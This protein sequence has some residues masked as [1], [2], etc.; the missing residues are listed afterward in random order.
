MCRRGARAHSAGTRGRC[1]MPPLCGLSAA[2]L[3]AV[4]RPSSRRG[5]P[6][7]LK[8]D[9]KDQALS[10]LVAVQDEHPRQGPVREPQGIPPA[11]EFLAEPGE[12]LQGLQLAPDAFPGVEREA[13][14]G[15]YGAKVL[16]PPGAQPDV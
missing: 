12:A 15:D 3:G 2:F 14:R 4:L 13:R 8:T 11:A 16:A 7:V 10:R 1:L 9:D 6:P 5:R